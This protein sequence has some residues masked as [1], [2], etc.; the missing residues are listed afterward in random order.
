MA[1]PGWAAPIHIHT[2]HGGHTGVE[3]RERVGG[4]GGCGWGGGLR[5][6]GGCAR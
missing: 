6:S 5:G 4:E 2:G 1:D 3:V